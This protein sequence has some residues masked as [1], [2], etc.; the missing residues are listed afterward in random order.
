MLH[1]MKDAIARHGADLVFLQEVQ[2]EHR[3][4]KGRI[5]SWPELSQYEFLADTLWPHT[6]YGRNAI[7]EQG[8]HG[9]AILSRHP[10]V[11]WENIDV[12]T[13]SLESRGVLHGVVAVDAKPIHVLCVHLSLFESG[14]RKQLKLIGERIRECVPPGEAVILAGDFNDWRGVA[15][16]IL[17]K[18][19]GLDEAFLKLQGRHARTFPSFLPALSL[20]R[21]YCRGLKPVR[22][23]T[24][25]EQ[26]WASLSDHLGIEV[27]FLL[28]S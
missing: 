12:S 3:L 8:H 11:S 1:Q 17:S 4:K 20:D 19:V 25:R 18:E 2:G 24:L 22:A 14:R 15:S 23:A 16:P 13:S 27:E 7:Y 9:N 5:R 6:A 10:F 21:V 26:P 28:G